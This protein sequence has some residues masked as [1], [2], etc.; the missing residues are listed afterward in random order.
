M[1]D[2]FRDKLGWINT[3]F[4]SSAHI[5][6]VRHIESKRGYYNVPNIGIFL[7]RLQ[8]YPVV[9][10]PAFSLGEGRYT[11]SQIGFDLPLYNYPQSKKNTDQ[12]VTELDVPIKIRRLALR[13]QLEIYNSKRTFAYE[14]SFKI[15]KKVLIDEHINDAIESQILPEDIL[16]CDLSR[17]DH[18]PPLGKVAVD[19][20]YGRIMFDKDEKIVDVHVHYYY[21]FS[22]EI[23]GGFYDRELSN[24]EEEEEET[25][26]YNLRA[27]FYHYR[28]SKKNQEPFHSLVEAVKKWETEVDHESRDA[29]FEFID[30]E[31]YTDNEDDTHVS[32]INEYILKIN[33]PENV[34]IIITSEN[35]HRPVI[36]LNKSLIISG[37]SGSNIVFDG[38]MFALS[39]KSTNST[40]DSQTYEKNST[41]IKVDKGN[42]SG[43]T[44]NHCTLVPTRNDNE[45]NG[46]LIF[47]WENID[48][49]TNDVDRLKTFL[50]D[51][52]NKEWIKGNNVIFSKEG[53]GNEIITISTPDRAAPPLKLLLVLNKDGDSTDI[54]SDTSASAS[55]VHIQE[56]VEIGPFSQNEYQTI[57]KLPVV[58]QNGFIRVFSSIYSIGIFGNSVDALHENNDITVANGNDNKNNSLVVSINKSIV[59]RID[60]LSSFASIK[61][62][63]S[64]VD[65]KGIIEAVRCFL[66][67]IE[68]STVFGK[69]S[70]EILDFSGNSIF[71]DVLAIKRRQQGCLRFCYVPNL[72]QIP[73][74]YRCVL[75]Y[76]TIKSIDSFS[77]KNEDEGEVIVRSNLSL[78]NQKAHR[79]KAQFTS[80]YYGEDGYAQL[81]KEVH[82]LIF[83]GGDHGSE[84]GAFNGLY[85]P[86]RLRNLSSSLGE[87]LKFGLE[88]GIFLVS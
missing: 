44:I 85:N 83:E 82:N 69:V 17:W 25:P 1:R 64:I 66:T 78:T 16:V 55:T 10:A 15:I 37:K 30:S 14:K 75:G 28:I 4:D 58:Q 38:L 59:G 19:P 3:P 20:E 39:N 71:T 73:R 45:N 36:I 13:K 46:R 68:N 33:I 84:M 23:G 65:G 74:P 48:Q 57:Y 9:N 56:L 53:L 79:I 8:P 6:D 67:H 21:G 35:L 5:I 88:A 18:P 54:D 11:F 42:L 87:Y 47:S 50:S 86:I 62:V 72:S 81:H 2:K 76:Q 26:N 52:L 40:D 29:L 61:V 31:V 51:L 80:I 24:S 63:D 27:D 34:T 7:W 41:I 32:A 70:S 49:N 60:S 12:T 43:L 77:N 22:G